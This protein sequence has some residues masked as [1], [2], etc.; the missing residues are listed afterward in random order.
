[1]RRS[2]LRGF[3]LPDSSQTQYHPLQCAAFIEKS[4]LTTGGS[5][6]RLPFPSFQNSIIASASQKILLSYWQ[7]TPHIPA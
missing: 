4:E 2:L 3:F 5:L 7:S 1:V 6:H